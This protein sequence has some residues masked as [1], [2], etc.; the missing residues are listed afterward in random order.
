MFAWT[1]LK[2]DTLAA[3]LRAL[4]GPRAKPPAQR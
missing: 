3:L 2:T 1:A 4:M